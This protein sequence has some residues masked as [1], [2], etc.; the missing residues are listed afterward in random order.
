MRERRGIVR[1]SAGHGDAVGRESFEG[2]DPRGDGGGET[3]G[4]E[5]AERLGLPR[6]NV[7][8]GPVVEEAE[9]EDVL[10][11]VGDGDGLAEELPGPMK[12]PT[13]SS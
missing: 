10:F 6:L 9:A 7:A 1:R 5:W 8:G 3:F 4:E 11:R 2:D 12:M 13:S